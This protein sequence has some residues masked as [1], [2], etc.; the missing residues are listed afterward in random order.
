MNEKFEALREK[1]PV[2]IYDGF[3]LIK[4]DGFIKI[5]FD[6]AIEGLCEFHPEIKIITD[7][8]KLINAFDSREARAIVFALG[9][10]EAVSYWK[11]ACPPRFIVRC[12]VL[13]EEDKLWWK[14]L[15]YNGL[16][17]LF[18]ING[19]E[20]DIEKFVKIEN[21]FTPTTE[22]STDSEENNESFNSSGINIIPV[23]G[24]KDSIVTMELLGDYRDKN[25]F[26]TVNDQSARTQ[27]VAAAGY[28]ERNMIKTYRT[29]DRELLQRNAEGFLNGHTPFSA[30]VAFLSYYCAY[31][32]GA[33]NIILSNEASAN[34][35][36]IEGTDINH[37]YAK[38][39]E[40]ECDFNDYISRNLGDRANY[41]SLLRA[42]NELQIAKQFAQYSKY[43]SVFRSCNAGSK[44]NIW[45][46]ECSKCLFVYIILSPFLDRGE[47]I[48]IFG[49]DMLEKDGLREEF[50][51]LIGVLKE[52]PFECIGTVEEVRCALEMTAKRYA[53]SNKET[54]PVLLDYYLSISSKS[55]DKSPA[56]L[57]G[58]FNHQNNIPKE[59]NKHVM[60]MYK[61]VSAAD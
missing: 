9:L 34:E 6:F 47:L 30:I 36:N 15:W 53:A 44:K 13:S 27:S 46:C 55:F 58:A 14:K 5:R 39:Y 45:C 41:F 43:H 51:G 37:Q 60:E 26:I 8:L 10:T 57:L 28:S 40:F 18:Y 38:S 56:D 17:E 54:L 1:Y 7:N 48:N 3:K 22:F 29:I 23:G 20:T 52:K 16:A 33:E 50:D 42:F 49:F 19:I 32:T 35:A 24:G 31:I 12:G 61:Y 21:D 25:L 11:C 59:F 4:S 2:F